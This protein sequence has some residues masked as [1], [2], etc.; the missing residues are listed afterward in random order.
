MADEQG[1]F[2]GESSS[3]ARMFLNSPA[4][5]AEKTTPHGAAIFRPFQVQSHTPIYYEPLREGTTVVLSEII[6]KIRTTKKE[7]QDF[8]VPHPENTIYQ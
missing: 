4:P 1:C 2:K 7:I 8:L 6:E 5:Q 3:C